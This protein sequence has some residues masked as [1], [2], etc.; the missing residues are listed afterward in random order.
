MARPVAGIDPITLEVVR[1]K[2]DGIANEMEL[3][4]LQSS[5]SPIVKESMDASA[6][7]FTVE[8]ET[9]AQALAI[10][11]H[12]AFLIPC[13]GNVLKNFPVA[14]MKPGDAYI[15]NDPYA[16]GTHLP[17]LAVVM[18][19]FAGDRVIALSA[20]MT[21][22]QDL[23][24]MQPGSVPTN[25]T[26]IFQEGIRIPALKLRDAQGWNETLVSMLKLNVRIPEVF[27]GDL[28]AQVAA[29]MIGAR[30][31]T[32]LA[33]AYGDNHLTALFAELLDR[34][35][36]M[37]RQAIRKLPQGT[38]R[39]VDFLDND[40]IELDKRVRIEVAAIVEGDTI[41]FDFT[42]T[43]KQVKGPI[44]CVPSGSQAAAY[45]A[46]RSLTGP[47]IPTNGGCFR[48]V[49][50]VLP[51]GSLVNPVEPAAV[52]TRTLTI[53]L[54][55]ACMIGAFREAMPDRLPASDA[56]DMHAIVWGGERSDGRRYVVSE[57]IGSGSGAA[58]HRDGID[59]VE[60]DV[61]NCMNLPVEAIELDC[62]IRVHRTEVRPDSGGPGRHRG[63][64][65][66]LREYEVLDGTVALTHRGERF[67]SAAPGLAGGEPGASSISRIVRADG[68]IET[69][70][71]KLVCTLAA[72]DRLI[73]GTAGGGG[74]GDKGARTRDAVR[75]DVRNGKVTPEAAR[76]VYG[77][78]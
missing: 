45:Y 52:N 77:L 72:G 34:S 65:G 29:C 21:H 8:G 18:P 7:L 30:R 73:V 6:S 76:A 48:P 10:P 68:T 47:Q 31:V 36:T 5:F 43:S 2:L 44:N 55:S 33:E 50:L 75:D 71:S 39:Y 56:V 66:I 38:F 4:L 49:R 17:D 64:L 78:S 1:N 46:V 53:K 62:P 61:T 74:Y 70:P 37:T 27:M 3:T 15:M 13:V 67:Y 24:G 22:H 41:T 32:A 69:I 40:G 60:T 35:E 63:G 16:G 9:L 28:N 11:A 19:V 59:V 58:A 20:T 51:E 23:G 14:V 54:A 12:L 25:A 26:E 57:C 42:G